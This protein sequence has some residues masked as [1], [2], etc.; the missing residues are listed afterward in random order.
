LGALRPAKAA[1]G[2]AK[3]QGGKGRNH[4]APFLLRLSAQVEVVFPEK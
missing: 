2:Q 4:F 3:Y 1:V